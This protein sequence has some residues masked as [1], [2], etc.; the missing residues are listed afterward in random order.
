MSHIISTNWSGSYDKSQNY[1]GNG[2]LTFSNKDTFKGVIYK[3]IDDVWDG[4]GLYT[5][6]DSGDTY[7]G[8]FIRHKRHGFGIKNINT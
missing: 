6:H 3:S 5:Y 4:K 2:T 7:D 1:F 8:E